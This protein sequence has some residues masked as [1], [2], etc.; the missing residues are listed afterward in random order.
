MFFSNSI[1]NQLDVLFKKQQ[2]QE[3][4]VRLR[5]QCV[6][7]GSFYLG[8]IFETAWQIKLFNS[9]DFNWGR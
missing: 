4:G 6:I 1:K 3:E 8:K 2:Q 7:E 9:L 5:F